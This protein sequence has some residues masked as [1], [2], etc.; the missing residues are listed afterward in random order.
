MHLVRNVYAVVLY[1]A[2]SVDRIKLILVLTNHKQKIN[3][4]NVC[5]YLYNRNTENERKTTVLF[6]I[7]NKAAMLSLSG[8]SNYNGNCLIKFTVV[9]IKYIICL[10]YLF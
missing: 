7:I 1:Y 8:M 2:T 5:R 4:K 6:A 3:N 10:N 9:Q